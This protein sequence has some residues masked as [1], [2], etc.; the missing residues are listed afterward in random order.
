MS[1]ND[2]T[3]KKIVD[4]G[5]HRA[6][7]VLSV[8]EQEA[9]EA[10]ED[11]EAAITLLD[12]CVRIHDEAK[13]AYEEKGNELLQI[14]REYCDMQAKLFKRRDELK[15]GYDI[16]DEILHDGYKGSELLT[17]DLCVAWGKVREQLS[18][19][20]C[21]TVQ[22]YADVEKASCDWIEAKRAVDVMKHGSC[23]LREILF[24]DLN[25]ENFEVLSD[26]VLRARQAYYEELRIKECPELEFVD[27]VL[28]CAT[29]VA[30][31]RKSKECEGDR[32]GKGNGSAV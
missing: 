21:V 25:G 13:K 20:C 10:Y 29:K 7:E 8:Y 24:A 31:K 32:D 9:L 19:L 16:N 14:R 18:R 11:L 1:D 17:T 22:L 27:E 5:R 30:A 23:E 28:A 6:D 26:S 3:A 15:E 2:K 4:D 12:E